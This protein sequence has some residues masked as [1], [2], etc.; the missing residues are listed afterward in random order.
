MHWLRGSSFHAPLDRYPYL[1]VPAIAAWWVDVDTRGAGAP[2]VSGA[3]APNTLYRR[4]TAAPSAADVARVSADVQA[5]FPGEPPFVPT[6]LGVFTWF[7]VGRYD[8]RIDALN[9][10]QVTIAASGELCVLDLA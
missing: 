9:T 6:L 3:P 7:A 10:F 1:A 4:L 2:A 8:A 5:S